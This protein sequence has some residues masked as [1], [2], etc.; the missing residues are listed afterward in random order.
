[1]P[2]LSIDAIKGALLTQVP[3]ESA[4]KVV[5]LSIHIGDGP[6]SVTIGLAE[7]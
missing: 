7:T 5:K 1:M 6:A 4:V 2:E 3:V